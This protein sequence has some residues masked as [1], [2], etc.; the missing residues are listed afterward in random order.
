[1]SDPSI[2]RSNI[3][4]TRK[5]KVSCFVIVFFL[6]N[7]KIEQCSMRIKLLNLQYSNYVQT[8]LSYDILLYHHLTR[9]DKGLYVWDDIIV[10]LCC[11]STTSYCE[12]TIIRYCPYWRVQLDTTEYSLTTTEY[13]PS[14][15][16]YSPSTTEY[17]PSTTEYSP[18]TTVYSPSTTEYSP[19]TP[20]YSPSTTE[21][22][23]STAKYS[24]STTE[25]SLSTTEYWRVQLSIAWVQPSIAYSTTCIY[26]DTIY[27]RLATLIWSY[28]FSL[29]CFINRL[30]QY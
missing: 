21:Y 18:S 3:V 26:M 7:I 19:S 6:I 9:P 13:S 23:P 27:L 14:T 20:E 30:E 10:G 22:S 16:E 11:F 17:S 24:L 8:E 4:R 25:Y 29:C 1:M 5:N 15:P 28:L 12:N 2:G